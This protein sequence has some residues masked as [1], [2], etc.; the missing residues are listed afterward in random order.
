MFAFMFGMDIYDEILK[1][2]HAMDQAALKTDLRQNLPLLGA[3][4]TIWNRNFLGYPTVALIPYSQAL[5]RY[6][7][8]IQQVEMESNGKHTDR[9]GKRV[10][11]ATGAIIWGEPG[12]S[13]QHSFYQ[14]I[15]QGTDIIPLELIGFKEGQWDEDL[16]LEG[17]YSQEKLLANLFAQAIALAT[18]QKSDNPNKSFEGN[19]PSHILLA[20]QL[21]PFTL[22]ALLSYFENRVA[23]EGFIWNIN[24]FDQE[25]VQL[26]KELSNKIIDRFALK[27]NVKGIKDKP[28][29][30]A[31]A[32]LKILDT[33]H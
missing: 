24:S 18:G 22:G 30:L 21:T 4:L 3:L 29:P 5:R 26:G 15:H 20:K 23:F 13:A 11:F 8:H 25:G 19:R 31:D 28:F 2:C 10:D 12:T 32:Y 6:S 14:L 9:H 16:E 27:R 7:A 1:G 17:T 33:I